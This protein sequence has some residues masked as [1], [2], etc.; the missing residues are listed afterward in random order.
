MEEEEE[1]RRSRGGAEEVEE[2]RRG[3]GGHSSS[4]PTRCQC[5]TFYT[6]NSILIPI[7]TYNGRKYVTVR[8]LHIYVP[9]KH[10]EAVRS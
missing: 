7:I 5:D 2:E 6:H 9:Q 10:L 1:R 3:E 4:S 8:V